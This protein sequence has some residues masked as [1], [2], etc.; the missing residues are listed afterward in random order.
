MS[1][2]IIYVKKLTFILKKQRKF[3]AFETVINE[4]ATI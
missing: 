4:A 2:S 3:A 1:K